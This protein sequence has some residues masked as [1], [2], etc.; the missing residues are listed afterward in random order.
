MSGE[1]KTHLSPSSIH[2]QTGSFVEWLRVA[3]T[4]LPKTTPA[5]LFCHLVSHLVSRDSVL[6]GASFS[7][8]LQQPAQ[9]LKQEVLRK[10]S[11]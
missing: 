7:L 3:G 10:A 8:H 1:L 4:V 5:C 6:E 9:V 2:P 11:G